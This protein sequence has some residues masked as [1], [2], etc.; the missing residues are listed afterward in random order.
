MWA[1]IFL[2]FRCQIISRTLEPEI[3]DWRPPEIVTPPC[4][5]P[6][7]LLLNFLKQDSVWFTLQ[8]SIEGTGSHRNTPRD[9]K[10]TSTN[11]H[12]PSHWNICS[13]THWKITSRWAFSVQIVLASRL[14]CP[15]CN[16]SAGLNLG[17]P[18]RPT[19]WHMVLHRANQNKPNMINR[20]ESARSGQYR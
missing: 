1:F 10:P 16:R 4:V 7:N 2:A 14:C 11:S 6:F 12:Q 9:F 15:A 5:K 17:S 18:S 20:S 13:G 19:S 8:M 3:W